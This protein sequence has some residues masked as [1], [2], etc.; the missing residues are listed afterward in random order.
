MGR[1]LRQPLAFVF[2]IFTCWEAFCSAS[3]PTK[4][5]LQRDD[6]AALL[7]PREPEMSGR[8]LRGFGGPQYTFHARTITYK[9]ERRTP[10]LPHFFSSRVTQRS[11]KRGG[12]G[13]G[14]IYNRLNRRRPSLKPGVSRIPLQPPRHEACDSD[15]DCRRATGHICVR[16]AHESSG[17]CQCPFYNP[18]EITIGS[19]AHCVTVKDIFDECRTT[20]ECTASNQNLQCVNQLCVCTSPYVLQND[21]ECVLAGS[22]SGERIRSIAQVASAVFAVAALS[23]VVCF[24]TRKFQMRRSVSD[25]SDTSSSVPTAD[26]SQAQSSAAAEVPVPQGSVLRKIK[27][28]K[29]TRDKVKAWTRLA[30]PH[31]GR[32]ST[33][34]P[35][36]GTQPAKANPAGQ[37]RRLWARG[38]QLGSMASP[39]YRN[40]LTDKLR[41]RPQHGEANGGSPLPLDIATAQ[42]YYGGPPRP[43]HGEA[44]GGNP[45]PVDPATAQAYYGGRPQPHAVPVPQ[46]VYQQPMTGSNEFSYNVPYA[47]AGT[48]HS[49]PQYPQRR[50]GGPY[51]RSD[52]LTSYTSYKFSHEGTMEDDPTMRSRDTYR[53]SSNRRYEEVNDGHPYDDDD[54]RSRK[55]VSFARR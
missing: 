22:I 10:R 19:R 28:P 18:V 35:L 31:F 42:A 40:K 36:E 7:R 9:E 8:S 12:A 24:M 14:I 41:E 29:V 20:Q 50:P 25:S 48:M 1:P 27:L 4:V 33:S 49:L 2:L 51:N 21:N 3:D 13:G 52:D 23:G 44:S 34:E 46:P 39:L 45:L 53:Q 37:L 43:Q 11:D 6:S 55:K 47:D 54:G 32:S 5:P 38:K 16:R 26:T 17:R 30:G 15:F